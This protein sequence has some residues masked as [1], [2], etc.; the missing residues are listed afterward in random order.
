MKVAQEFEEHWDFPNCIGAIDGKRVNIRKPSGSGSFYF[1]YKKSFC[2]AMMAVANAKHE[3]LMVDVG[4]NGRMSDGGVIRHTKFGEMFLCNSL[5]IPEPT[6]ISSPNSR[7]PFV[8]VGDDAFTISE[9]LLKPY[10]SRT[11]KL[12]I[13]EQIF[14]Y[15]LSRACRVVENEFGSLTATFGVFQRDILLVPEKAQT[16]VLACCYLHFF[17]NS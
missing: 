2:I 13:Q 10:T 1:N 14:N 9:N 8:F 15:R 12:D 4:I 16:I 5:G 11:G 6:N 7:L 3:I 17:F